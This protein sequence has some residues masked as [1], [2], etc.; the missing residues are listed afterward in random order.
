MTKE[1]LLNILVAIDNQG[2]T[3]EDLAG[4]NA[5]FI[6]VMDKLKT[7]VAKLY[8]LGLIMCIA[9]KYFATS[10]GRQALRDNGYYN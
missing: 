10:E 4:R 6:I 3:L 5:D 8:E 2:A 7:A 1:L 9:G